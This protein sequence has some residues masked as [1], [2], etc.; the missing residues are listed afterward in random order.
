MGDHLHGLPKVIALSLL[1]YHLHVHAS[2]GHIVGLGGANVQE[3]FVVAEIQVGLRPVLGDI[4]FPVLIGVHGTGV[5][6]DV[7]IEFLD[8]DP[9]ASGLQQL[10]Q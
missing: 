1:P 5:H 10:R 9:K 2:S 4:T 8:G 7:R 3:P 6:V